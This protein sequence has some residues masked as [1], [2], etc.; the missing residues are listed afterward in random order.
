MQIRIREK[1]FRLPPH[2]HDTFQFD[3]V[4]QGEIEI[5]IQGHNCRVPAQTLCI[6]PPGC[7]HT[8]SSRPCSPATF[9]SVHLDKSWFAAMNWARD[10]FLSTDPG[11]INLYRIA[12]KSLL[13]DSQTAELDLQRLIEIL[14]ISERNPLPSERKPSRVMANAKAYIMSRLSEHV[15]LDELS[16]AAGLPIFRL[17]KSFARAYGIPPHSYHL[18]ARILNARELLAS[19]VRPAEVAADLGF[20]DQSHFGRHFRKFTGLSP[21]SYQ[22]KVNYRPTAGENE[23]SSRTVDCHSYL[24][25]TY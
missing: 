22:R 18:C 12:H 9:L 13:D 10:P 25:S 5:E 11:V 1:H 2:F 8:F 15:S 20:A 14:N 24:G 6:I 21:A 3:L 19:G 7:V 4:E 23:N 16:Q 17:V